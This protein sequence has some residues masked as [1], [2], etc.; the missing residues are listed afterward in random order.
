M[1]I[2]E[3][4]IKS[5]QYYSSSYIEAEKKAFNKVGGSAFFSSKVVS[6][7]LEIEGRFVKS[8]ANDFLSEQAKRFPW[9]IIKDFLQI[10]PPLLKKSRYQIEKELLSK[11]MDDENF[12]NTPEETDIDL[13]TQYYEEGYNIGGQTALQDIKSKFSKGNSSMKALSSNIKTNFTL[14]DPR[15][16]SKLKWE[17]GKRIVGINETT[18]RLIINELINAYDS[19]LGAEGM[20]KQLSALFSSW[21]IN[22]NSQEFTNKRA[23]LIARTELSQSVSWA[24][25]ESYAQRDVRKKSWL[26]EPTACERCTQ[27]MGDGIISFSQLFSIGLLGPIAHPRCRCTLLPEVEVQDYLQGYTWHGEAENASHSQE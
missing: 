12:L 4:S 1:E 13:M 24:R 25:E 3:K 23:E 15:V 20:K 19:G 5:N 26:A 6:S 9:G 27:A 22:N 14:T 2:M 7:Y 18:R 17:G 11:M 16:R 10:Y 8:I 21:R